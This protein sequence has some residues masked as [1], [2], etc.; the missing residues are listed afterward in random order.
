M[1]KNCYHVKQ[2]QLHGDEYYEIRSKAQELLNGTCGETVFKT[3]L[4]YHG[5]VLVTIYFVQ[6]NILTEKSFIFLS[7]YTP[8]SL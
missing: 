8:K 7:H 3:N 6:K 5:D 1:S 4:N 2:L